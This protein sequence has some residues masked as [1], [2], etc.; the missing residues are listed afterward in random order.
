MV[1]TGLQKWEFKRGI[2]AVKP[3]MQIKSSAR[4]FDYCMLV[5]VN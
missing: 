3:V 1:R 5:F 2:L 4:A